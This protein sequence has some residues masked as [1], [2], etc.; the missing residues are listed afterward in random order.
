MTQILKLTR[1]T[2]HRS[3]A[4]ELLPNPDMRHEW[5]NSF[6]VLYRDSGTA[7]YGFL[8]LHVA[9]EKNRHAETVEWFK[10]HFI[11]FILL[12][13]LFSSKHHNS[14]QLYFRSLINF[15]QWLIFLGVHQVAFAIR[16]SL[17][18]E[19]FLARVTWWATAT[20]TEWEATGYIKSW[21][22]G[23]KITT[24]FFLS[25][26]MQVPQYL[27]SQFPWRKQRSV[28]RSTCFLMTLCKGWQ[29]ST[30]QKGLFCGVTQGKNF[31]PI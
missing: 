23:P 6:D 13:S 15:L 12:N 24:K 17:G 7:G 1:C 18:W 19:T 3:H 4:A 28:Q 20:Q 14:M 10:E 25:F 11:D 2:P 31:S 8:L 5:E 21:E 26:L 27:W 22:L 9:G 29:L 30:L 16:K